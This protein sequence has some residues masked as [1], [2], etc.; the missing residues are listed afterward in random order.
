MFLLVSFVDQSV[1]VELRRKI[2]CEPQVLVE[3]H[4]V[5]VL[6]VESEAVLATEAADECC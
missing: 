1:L 5:D 4:R 2:P 6:A 3:G